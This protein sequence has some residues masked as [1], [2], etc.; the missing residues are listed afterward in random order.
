MDGFGWIPAEWDAVSAEK[1]RA[2]T[3]FARRQYAPAFEDFRLGE[4]PARALRDLLDRCRAEKV[5]VALVLMPEGS[6]FR[7]WYPPAME[8]EMADF[9]GGLRREHGVA[10]IDA[11]AWVDDAGFWDSHHLLPS[12]AAVF[13][14]RLA[15][16]VSRLDGV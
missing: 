5:R 1:R 4:A 16:E 10:V 9:L 14:R 7:G 6:E 15:D 2:E 11:R 3:D 12:G 13:T 8:A